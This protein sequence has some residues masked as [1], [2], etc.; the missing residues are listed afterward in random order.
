[1]PRGK[2]AYPRTRA[3]Q[4]RWRRTGTAR[5]RSTCHSAPDSP[6]QRSRPSK[7]RRGTFGLAR[8]TCAR[9]THAGARC[10]A[11][12]RPPPIPAWRNCSAP[13]HTRPR[14]TPALHRPAVSGWRASSRSARNRAAA[15]PVRHSS[16]RG[17]PPG[18]ARPPGRRYPPSGRMPLC[19]R[20]RRRAHAPSPDSR[21]LR[22]RA[23]VHHGAYGSS[24]AA[25]TLCE[26]AGTGRTLNHATGTNQSGPKPLPKT[27]LSHRRPWAAGTSLQQPIIGA[28][29]RR[30][31][32]CQAPIAVARTNLGRAIIVQYSPE[33]HAGTMAFQRL[34]TTRAPA[35]EIDVQTT[36]V[37]KNTL[38]GQ[39]THVLPARLLLAHVRPW[40][41]ELP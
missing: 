22:P 38:P 11:A 10:R 37:D 6:M 30:N 12:H 31:A 29:P 26:V 18:T 1:M 24:G 17:C 33:R 21:Q 14:E 39:S 25:P 13:P 35:S 19:V 41:D 23:P 27:S 34:L 36:H 16:S 3:G 7:N 2:S 28:I 9:T 5:L 4:A 32:A 8:R 20:E 15:R 40:P